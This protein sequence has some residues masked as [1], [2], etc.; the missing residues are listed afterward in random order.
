MAVALSLSCAG[1]PALA[2][3]IAYPSVPASETVTLH[4]QPVEPAPKVG[5]TALPLDDQTAPTDTPL[6]GDTISPEEAARG[7]DT[8]LLSQL[9]QNYRPHP[10]IWRIGDR[11]TTIYLF[12]TVHVLPPGFAWRDAAIDAI[13]AKADTL[14]VEAIDED[15]VPDFAVTYAGG[16]ALPPLAARVS[17]D[18]RAAL[19][20]FTDTLPPEAAAVLDGMPTWIAAIAVGFARDT[21][22]GELPGPGADDW[23]EAQFRSRHKPVIAIEDAAKVM[24]QVN[25]VAEAEQRKTLDKALDTPAATRAER[26]APTHAWAQGDLGPGSALTRDLAVTTGGDALGGALLAHRNRAWADALVRRLKVPGTA[27]FAAGAG[28]FIGPDSVLALLE[29]RGVRVTRVQ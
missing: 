9:S 12:G 14:I 2:Q 20:R 7:A 3:R 29:K 5:Y 15:A 18:H 6:D 21:Q 10:A 26:R 27:L 1:A 25:A 22:A 11:D 4:G 24:G 13:V 19:R 8:L 28:H 23:I 16:S 17:P